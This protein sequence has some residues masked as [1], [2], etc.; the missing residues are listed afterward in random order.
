[1]ELYFYTIFPKSIFSNW[2][3]ENFFL[4]FF[5]KVPRNFFTRILDKDGHNCSITCNIMNF[6][7]IFDVSN[8]SYIVHPVSTLPIRKRELKC[9]NIFNFSIIHLKIYTH[10]DESFNNCWNSAGFMD[11]LL[12]FVVILS[13]LFVLCISSAT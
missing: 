4:I 10:G 2:N 8:L 12:Y 1:M 9:I 3:D 6:L 7:K 13:L 11:V 5:S